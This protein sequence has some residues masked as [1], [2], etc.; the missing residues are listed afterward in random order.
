M[1]C[2][3]TL[4]MGCA[5]DGDP[6]AAGPA[7]ANGNANVKSI[8]VSIAP[9]QWSSSGAVGIDFKQNFGITNPQ[10]TQAII[11]LGSVHVYLKDAGSDSP[12]PL[13][14]PNTGSNFH[15]EYSVELNKVTISKFYDN[16]SAFTITQN[17]EFKVVTIAGS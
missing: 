17:T 15:Y 12:L 10:I 16:W 4:F 5:K 9:G 8:T 13:I 6:G 3:S 14:I 1:L 7:G 2:A 11:D